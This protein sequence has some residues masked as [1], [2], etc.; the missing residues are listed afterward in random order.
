[1][2]PLTHKVVAARWND[3]A[4]NDALCSLMER[5]GCPRQS[6]LRVADARNLAKKKQWNSNRRLRDPIRRLPITRDEATARSF[7]ATT[8]RVDAFETSVESRCV[9]SLPPANFIR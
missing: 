6:G 3:V 9:R 2:V 1:M 5:S 4:R 7:S 8:R